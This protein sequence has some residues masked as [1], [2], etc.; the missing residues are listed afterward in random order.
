M[1]KGVLKQLSLIAVAMLTL[2]VYARTP[3][4]TEA[5]FEKEA[6]T[7]QEAPAENGT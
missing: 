7:T 1:R 3:E 4:T 5:L 2:A 6:L